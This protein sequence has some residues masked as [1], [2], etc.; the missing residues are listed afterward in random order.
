MEK[1][2]MTTLVHISQ[3]Y[4]VYI[5]RGGKGADGYFGNPHPIGKPCSHCNGAIHDRTSCLAAYQRDFE[6][7]IARDA[8]F[9]RRILE[10][11]GK[12]LGCFCK[13]PK[14]PLPCHGDIIA[15]W[16]DRQAPASRVAPRPVIPQFRGEFRFLANPYP[17]T[18]EWRKIVCPSS[19][20]AYQ[21]SKTDNAEWIKKLLK[22][23][24]LR[25]LKAIGHRLPLRPNWDTIKGKVMAQILWKKFSD[26]K[27][28]ASLLATGDA[29]LIE[30]NTWNDTF[31][32]RDIRTGE[33]QNMLGKL[34]MALRTKLRQEPPIVERPLV[35]IISGGQTGADQ[36]GLFTAEAFGILTGGWAPKGWLTSRGPAPALLRDRFKLQ[37]HTGRYPA[38]TFA[39][40][41]EA[42]G[43]IRLAFDFTTAG[44]RCTLRAIEENYRPYFD[45]DLAHPRPAAEAV[46][47]IREHCIQI[48]NVAG[49]REHAATPG[50]FRAA[51]FY[52]RDVLVALGYERIPRSA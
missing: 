47:W 34:L 30:G 3:P 38:R 5:G 19:E 31:W 32:G 41:K 2:P 4:D 17:H 22:A 10:L 25:E 36:A 52:L 35:K 26:P 24:D 29:D 18:M 33:G 6:T 39:N 23:K 21:L 27:L 14:A 7:R 50:T 1:T 40:A 48:L 8:E 49:N 43:T 11:R 9:R 28:R 12:R 42:H 13:T 15:A 46:A 37:E 20:V 51:C 16:L 44:E 45:V